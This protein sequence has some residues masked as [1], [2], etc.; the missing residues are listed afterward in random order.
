[1]SCANEA[2]GSITREGILTRVYESKTAQIVRERA[3]RKDR[4]EDKLID[5]DSMSVAWYYCAHVAVCV[6]QK[7]QL[8]SREG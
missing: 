4:L 1:M 3:V 5:K 6:H 2:T 7:D 8:M